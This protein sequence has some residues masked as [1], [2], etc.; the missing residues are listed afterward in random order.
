MI[1]M[2]ILMMIMTMMRVDVAPFTTDPFT[3]GPFTTRLVVKGS[4]IIIIIMIVIIVA[5]IWQVRDRE[6]GDGDWDGDD[7]GVWHRD[8]QA[9]G[10]QCD[11]CASGMGLI[12]IIHYFQ[13]IKMSWKKKIEPNFYKFCRLS[14]TK[15]SKKNH[16]SIKAPPNT[17]VRLHVYLV[18]V[19]SIEQEL[20]IQWEYRS[21]RN[22]DFKRPYLGN[23][24]W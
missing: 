14:V 23:E 10:W 19:K 11:S 8:H 3:T 6:G 20:K 1:M 18:F 5:V 22:F 13:R 24:K 7:W 4:V 16:F 2:M 12:I 15:I 21:H 17:A 9:G